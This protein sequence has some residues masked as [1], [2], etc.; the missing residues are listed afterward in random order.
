MESDSTIRMAISRE[1]YNNI[2]YEWRGG[3]GE[4]ELG[5]RTAREEIENKDN[6]ENKYET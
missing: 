5:I 3:A 4:R 1:N 2:G 6:N